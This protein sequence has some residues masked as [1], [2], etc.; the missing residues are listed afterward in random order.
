MKLLLLREALRQR[1]AE[2]GSHL[3]PGR[4]FVADAVGAI[5]SEKLQISKATS[6]GRQSDQ[7]DS[8]SMMQ[9]K[10]LLPSKVEV[11]KRSEGKDGCA[12][13]SLRLG[14]RPFW[15]LLS[16]QGRVNSNP[17]RKS[18]D[19]HKQRKNRGTRKNSD[20]NRKNFRGR[21]RN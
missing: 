1:R 4:A 10:R 19:T 14:S 7:G 3:G 20:Y 5:D 6:N 2:W 13:A 16:G 12:W 17:G 9:H 18:D 21:I 15:V 11:K 8:P